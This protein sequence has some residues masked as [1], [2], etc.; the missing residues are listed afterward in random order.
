MKNAILKHLYDSDLKR[1]I[2]GFYPN[3]QIDKTLDSSLS[4]SLLSGTF[5][6]QDKPVLETM[7]ALEEKLWISNS[8]S[9][10]ARY[11]D[12]EYY[13]VSKDI[14]GNPWIICTLWLARW[15]IAKAKSKNDLKKAVELLGWAAKTSSPTGLLA[16]QIDPYTGEPKSVSPLSWS[17]AEF[18]IAASEYVE[19]YKSL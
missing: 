18:V 6:A 3:G 2:R 1:F 7:R 16:E 11:E 15:Q 12:D 10:M 19:K 14:K 13:R 17:H 9:G 8:F 4:F 5:D